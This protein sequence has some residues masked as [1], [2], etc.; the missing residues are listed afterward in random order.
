MK[1]KNLEKTEAD[2]DREGQTGTET[3]TGRKVT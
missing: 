2:K 1:K 3:E